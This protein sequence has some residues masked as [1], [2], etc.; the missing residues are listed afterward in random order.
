M[1]DPS[2]IVTVTLN[3]AIDLT[4]FLDRLDVGGVNR[5]RSQHRQAGGKGVNVSAMLGAWGL[6]GT[7]TGF[8][9]AD[10]PELFVGLFHRHRIRDEFIR[11]PGETRTGIKIVSEDPRETTDLNF[12][13]LQPTPAELRELEEK[14]RKLARPGRWFVL[15]GSLPAGLGSDFFAKTIDLL[16]RGGA[17]V[18]VDTSGNALKIAIDAGVDLIKPNAHELAEVLGHELADFPSC[19]EAARMVQRE[20]VSHVV[21]SLGSGGALFVT[22]ES[23]L[24]AAAPPVKVVSTVGA[25]DSLLAGCLAGLVTGRPP[26]EVAKLGTAF[27]WCA[28]EDVRRELPAAAEIQARLSRINVRPL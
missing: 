16:K 14:L 22:P 2:E 23:A 20:K 17:K 13:G 9:G 5:A 18:A 7:A 10:N 6:P 12:P 15:A 28:L 24:L 4:V 1:S 11:I 25:G 8:L 21:V 27:A 19:V 3:P 26:E